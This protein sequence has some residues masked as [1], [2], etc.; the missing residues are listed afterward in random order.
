MLEVNPM[1]IWMAESKQNCWVI[2]L[3][4]FGWLNI[5]QNMRS[6]VVNADSHVYL[7]LGNLGNLAVLYL[8][9]KLLSIEHH[10]SYCFT[11]GLN[12][13]TGYWEVGY[14]RVHSQVQSLKSGNTATNELV[15]SVGILIPIVINT[16][17]AQGKQNIWNFQSFI[18]HSES[19]KVKNTVRL[20]S[21]N[22]ATNY[23]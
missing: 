22:M 17:R 10:H 12:C 5:N 7:T 23:T 19:C 2:V 9:V 4:H 8:R 16:V 14:H 3:L 11:V 13:K 20:A 18:P 1:D 21:I 15:C 6:S